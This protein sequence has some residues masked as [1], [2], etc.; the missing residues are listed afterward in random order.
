M[1]T[2]LGV[3]TVIDRRYVQGQHAEP[4]KKLQFTIRWLF[5]EDINNFKGI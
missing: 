2:K 1:L 3:N 5:W 4:Q